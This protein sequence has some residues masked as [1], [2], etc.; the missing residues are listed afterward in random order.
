MKNP[1]SQKCRTFELDF[2]YI[3]YYY[4]TMNTRREKHIFYLIIVNFLTDAINNDINFTLNCYIFSVSVKAW[5]MG[6]THLSV[7]ELISIMNV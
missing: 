4:Y 1:L 3:L 5:S 7:C 6:L 2:P